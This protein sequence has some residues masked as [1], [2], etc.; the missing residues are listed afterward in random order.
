M[1]IACPSC[2]AEY[3]VPSASLRPHLK[4]RCARCNA[5][6]IP[7]QDAVA[8]EPEQTPAAN[9]ENQPVPPVGQTA[10][11]RLAA[12]PPPSPSAMLRAAWLVTV[13]LLA[14]S[15]ASALIWRNHVTRMWPASAWLLGMVDRIAPAQP[16]HAGNKAEKSHD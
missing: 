2:A 15:A 12:A 3:E 16:L 10:M 11:D 13:L 1:R 14:G 6:W 5:E 7:V 8:V 9:G 4:V